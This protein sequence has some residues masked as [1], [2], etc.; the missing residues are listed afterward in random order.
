M[1]NVDFLLRELA[2]PD[3]IEDASKLLCLSDPEDKWPQLG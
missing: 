2:A 3:Q 1:P